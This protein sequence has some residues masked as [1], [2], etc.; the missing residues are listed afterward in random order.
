M[1]VQDP[2]GDDWEV[3]HPAFLEAHR[4]FLQLLEEKH[5]EEEREGRA[6]DDHDEGH[7]NPG[8]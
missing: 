5:W 1:M 2:L 6:E 8:R 4:H 3:E 7:Q